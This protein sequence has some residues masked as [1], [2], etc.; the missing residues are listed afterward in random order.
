MSAGSNLLIIINEYSNAFLANVPILYQ[1][2]TPGLPVFS[3]YKIVNNKAKGESQSVCYKK[4]K[5]ANFP[6]NKHFLT[7]D[8][9]LC[10]LVTTVLRFALLPYYRG[11]GN[12]C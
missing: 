4:T 1:L 9:L 11:N 6:R 7:P 3:R 8:D 12:I 2:K 10:F 5:H